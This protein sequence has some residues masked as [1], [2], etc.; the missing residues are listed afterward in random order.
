MQSSIPQSNYPIT[1]LPDYQMSNPVP[2]AG[3]IVI[4]KR[5][6]R[7]SVL[8]VR[9]KKDPTLWIFPKGHI[10]RGETA[11]SAALRE[12]LEEAGIEGDIVAAVGE[13]IEFDTG[14]EH[15]R[16]EYFLIRPVTETSDTDG[17]E[18]QWFAIDDAMNELRYESARR[19]LQSAVNLVIG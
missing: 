2:Q 12:T 15:V 14:R 5:G 7:M 8:L 10:E 17:R 13:P 6:D 4:R 3:G 18:K 16:V 11:E 1:R 19:L 9:A